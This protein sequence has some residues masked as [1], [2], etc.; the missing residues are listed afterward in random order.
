M[1]VAELSGEDGAGATETLR[2]IFADPLLAGE[3][4]SPAEL[5]EFVEAAPNA[6]R[7][8]ARLFQAY[9][10]SLERLSDLSHRMAREGEAP[11]AAAA[12][13][14]GTRVAAYFEEAG[15]YFHEIEEA[16]ETLAAELSPRDDP[17]ESLR[18]RLADIF[19]VEVRILPAQVMPVEQL[20]YDRHTLRLFISERVP[21]I[22]R[23][24]LVARQLAFLSHRDLLDRLTL[25]AGMT[26]PEAAR[27]AR[28][29]FAVRLAEAI[30][31]PASRFA[32]AARES[33][34]DIAL[35]SQRFVLRPSRVM[36]RL[37]TLGANGASGLPPA[38][39]IVLDGSG[40][41]LV[42]MPGAGFPMPRLAPFCARLPIFDE[43]RTDEV[44]AAD[45]DL[46][47]GGRFRAVVVIE[48]GAGTGAQPRP[49]R[50]AMIGWRA[51]EG[52]DARDG[53]ARPIGVTCRLC[54]RLDCAHRIQ[55]PI[56]QPGG[57]SST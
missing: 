39:L 50:R 28:S 23:P 7:G 33:D 42:R 24:F 46:P 17:M 52:A 30:L 11:T 8:M 10:E 12:R 53:K 20:R 9:R 43:M 25:A 55:P 4:A 37:V 21:L 15:P 45:L 48:D 26:D 1:D 6:A 16:A 54:E 13:L 14:P 51:T 31:A 47:D 5:S 2:E 49:R 18:R 3:V 40:A 35:M 32:P 29:S 22:D 34:R 56:S 19:R 57:L 41:P 27:I 38:F 44:A 36:A